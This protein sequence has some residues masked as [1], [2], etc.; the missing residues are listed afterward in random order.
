MIIFSRLPSIAPADDFKY[1]RAMHF[2]KSEDK[3]VADAAIESCSRHLWYLTGKLVVF[4]LFDE[5][6]APFW[7]KLI[8]MKLVSIERPVVFQPTKPTFPVLSFDAN[9]SNLSTLPSFVG[10]RSWL[11]FDLLKLGAEQVEWMNLPVEYW[12]EMSG[13]GKAKDFVMK[14]E[15]AND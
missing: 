9:G 8:A 15:V 11:L 10:R 12:C 5:T 4:S 3:E 13:Y 6:L 14:L 1:L 7:R 2:Y